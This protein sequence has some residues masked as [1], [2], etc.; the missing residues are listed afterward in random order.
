MQPP[1]GISRLL[2]LLCFSVWCLGIFAVGQDSEV[3]LQPNLR[4]LKSEARRDAESHA[5]QYVIVDLPVKK[6]L[7]YYPELKG[8]AP[9]QSQQELPGLLEKVGANQKLLLN[10]P[11]VSAVESVV[12]QDVDK[13]GWP[14]GSPA[15]TGHFNYLVRAHV[16]GEGV[17]FSEGR[18]DDHFRS[19]DPPVT[20]GYSLIQGFALLPMHFHPYHQEAGRFLYLGRQTLNNREYHVVAF[21]QKPEK[22]EL[23]GGVRVNGADVTVAYQGLAWIDP[24]TFQI[25]RMRTDFLKA[26][27]EVGSEMTDAQFSEVHLPVINR[28]FWLPNEAI[29]TRRTKNGA[30]EEKHQFSEYKIFVK[31]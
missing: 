29:V 10:L 15:F 13:H 24:D 30:I 27:P 17:R 18:A 23:L 31:Q 20:S 3:G 26:R 25:V 8:L 12:Q 4:T 5:P 16:T 1:A 9:A 21:A 6:I 28:S 11:T 19:T 2:V 14:V 7:G 22:A